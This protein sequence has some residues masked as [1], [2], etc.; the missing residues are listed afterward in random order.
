[1]AP[2]VVNT[3]KEWKLACPKGKVDLVFPTRQGNVVNVTTLT[4]TALGPL[5]LAAG[6]TGIAAIRAQQPELTER[7]ATE[8]GIYWALPVWL[9]RFMGA[10]GPRAW[11]TNLDDDGLRKHRFASHPV[12]KVAEDGR[13]QGTRQEAERIGAKRRDGA[14]RWIGKWEKQLIEEQCG[15]CAADQEIVPFAAPCCGLKPGIGCCTH[16]L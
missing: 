1:M 5:Q 13:A 2:I 7:R 15:G 16:G 10:M 3:L 6:I 14:Q 12:A 9:C 8:P 4:R 11:R